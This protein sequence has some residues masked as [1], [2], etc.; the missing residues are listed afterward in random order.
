MDG[1][2]PASRGDALPQRS[3]ARCA[4]VAKRRAAFAVQLVRRQRLAPPRNVS[5]ENGCKTSV[6][7][8]CTLKCVAAAADDVGTPSGSH[9]AVSRWQRATATTAAT[10]TKEEERLAHSPVSI[11]PAACYCS[12]SPPCNSRQGRR[13]LQRNKVEFCAANNRQADAVRTN[14]M[15]LNSC[16]AVQS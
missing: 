14:A 10:S 9:S 15:R 7:L 2:R 12:P 3:V 6:H 1:E 8:F 5:R 4:A 13:A 16:T 11:E